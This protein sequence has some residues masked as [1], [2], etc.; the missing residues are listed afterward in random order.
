MPGT[1]VVHEWI[2]SHGGSENVAEV[3]AETLDADVHCLWRDDDGTRFVG[4]SVHES[5]LARA[6]ALRGHKAAALPLMPWVW[7]HTDLSGYDRL[8]ISSH[9]FAH[10]VASSPLNR[11]IPAYVYVH[12]PARYI[13]APEMDHRGDTWWVRAGAAPLRRLD[14][15]RVAGH[16]WFAANSEFVRQRMATTW[17]VDATVIHPPVEVR[18]IQAG[19][20]WADRVT[21]SDQDLLA[22]LPSA[23]VL[24]ASR[25]VPYKRLE[26]AIT[27]GNDLGLPVVLAGSGPDEERLRAAAD[28]SSVPV[29]FVE[30]PSTEF[31][32]ALYEATSLFV[33]AAIEDFGIMPVEAMAVGTPCLVN[34]VGGARE[35]VEAAGGGRVTDFDDPVTR[36]DAAH[37]ALDFDT[38]RIRHAATGFDR[39]QFEQRLVEW[40]RHVDA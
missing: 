11:E 22:S 12:T 10:Q 36:R 21:D 15:A 35:S 28:D 9:A 37:M 39:S 26:A 29:T 6:G 40:T 27:V 23:F 31:L 5:W 33:F 30:R 2:A 24:G 34:T 16:A 20:P 25:F 4:R 8:V 14:R 3:L 7:R 18:A 32:Y 17:G 38:R 19:M 1:A 13:W